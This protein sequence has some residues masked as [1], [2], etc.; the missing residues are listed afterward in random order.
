V[1]VVYASQS[2]SLAALELL[3]HLESA[4]IL[5]HYVA[6][7]IEFP[8]SAVEELPARRLPVHWR[9]SPAPSALQE[10]GTRWVRARR[11]AVLRVPSAVIPP[12]SNYLL[13]PDHPGFPRFVHSAVERFDFDPRLRARR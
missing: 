10:I 1:A 11:S 7:Q 13:N 2:L 8:E 6:Y 12:E 3:V 4:A 5:G 9:A